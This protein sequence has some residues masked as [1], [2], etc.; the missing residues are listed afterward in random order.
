MGLGGAVPKRLKWHEHG[1]T[2][3]AEHP[4][5]MDATARF[6]GWLLALGVSLGTALLVIAPFFWRGNASG[7]DIGFHASSW[8]EVAGQRR[9]GILFPGRGEWANH[10]FGEPGFIFYP[11]LW[12]MLGAGR[13]F[14]VPWTAV[15]E[16]FM[17]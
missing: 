11:P 3:P 12:M 2:S 5:K 1:M 16:C 4:N 15:P 14:G 6:R 9:E 17:V 10:G 13:R 7:H 8:L